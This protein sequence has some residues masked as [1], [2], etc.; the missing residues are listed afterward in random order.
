MCKG[1]DPTCAEFEAHHRQF[2]DDMARQRREFLA[3]EFAAKGGGGARRRR[4]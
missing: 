3:S 1:D 2:L 4:D